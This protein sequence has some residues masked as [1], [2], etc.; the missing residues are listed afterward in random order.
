MFND[1]AIMHL[2]YRSLPVTTRCP[3]GIARGITV[4]AQAQDMVKRERNMSSLRRLAGM[5][6]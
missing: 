5:E 4:S 6:G 2:D 1:Y 3:F